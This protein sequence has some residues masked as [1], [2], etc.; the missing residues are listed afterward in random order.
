MYVLLSPFTKHFYVGKTIC[1]LRERLFQHLLDVRGTS[2]TH[3]H[4]W[5]RKFG[6]HLYCIIPMAFTSELWRPSSTQR[7]T[8]LLDGILRYSNMLERTSHRIGESC[9]LFMGAL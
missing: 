8:P 2:R 1:G 6:A 7:W 4:R 3:V 5:L 9:V